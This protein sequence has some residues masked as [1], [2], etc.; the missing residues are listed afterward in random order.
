LLL[1]SRPLPA[2]CQ[3]PSAA[4][5][6]APGREAPSAEAPPTTFAIKRFQVRG[7]TLLPARPITLDE[8]MPVPRPNLVD[9]LEEFLGEGKGIQEIEAARA[10]L[11]RVYHDLGYPT[12][13]VNIPEQTVG[14]EGTILLDVVEGK[15]RRV[16][17]TG[18]RYFTME[19]IIK[20]LPTLHE[21][22]LIYLPRLQEELAVVNSQADMRVEPTLMPGKEFG[23]VDVELKVEDKMPLHGSLELNNRASANTHDLRLNGV[24]HYDNLWQQGHSLSGQFQTS[25]EDIREVRVLSASYVLPPPWQDEHRLA[26]Y[27][28]W[29]DSETGF[30]EG[31]TVTGSGFIS[32]ARYVIPLTPYEQY[33]HNLTAG[34]DYKAFEETVGFAHDPSL[35]TPIRYWPLSVAYSGSLP[36]AHGLTVFSAALNMCFRELRADPGQFAIKRSQSRGGYLF[37]T[38]GVERRQQLPWQ[39][40]LYLKLDGQLASEPLIANEQYIVGG[41]ESMR[42]YQESFES[43][44]N[45][46]HFVAEWSGRDLWPA[47]G[48]TA[49]GSAEPFLFYEFANLRLESP[50]PQQDGEFNLSD[51]GVGI[52]GKISERYT[53]EADW[54]TALTSRAAV[55]AGEQRLSFLLK[56]AF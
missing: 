10:K 26:L 7:N 21:G 40:G 2:S 42:G 47:T 24:I 55:S 35:R 19:S 38:F 44:D 29:S 46:L 25:P 36:D 1:L 5:T 8:E 52:R 17:V 39:T 50:L 54:A 43:A 22:N 41:M 6:A 11:E 32:G 49:P 3:E 13:L 18:N 31:F 33:N 20:D 9:T 30:G 4:D 14:A 15:V 45:A 56:Y 12:V 16:R 51:A 27:G 53:F 37:G 28:I 34:L 23:T 48:F